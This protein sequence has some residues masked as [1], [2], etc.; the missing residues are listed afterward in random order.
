MYILLVFFSEF[1]FIQES[2]SIYV[3]P[4]FANVYGSYINC[5]HRSMSQTNP[6]LF[7]RF[8][9]T[10]C[11]YCTLAI[12]FCY[13]RFLHSQKHSPRDIFLL[14]CYKELHLHSDRTNS[15]SYFHNLSHRILAKKNPLLKV[16]NKWRC[17]WYL[18]TA[19]EY[20][21]RNIK[22]YVEYK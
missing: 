18:F 4:V 20:I 13:N 2:S 14:S 19:N 15:C 8:T 11:F 21:V 5:V 7:E 6:C 1:C 22:I 10:L 17:I 3:H 9:C 16:Q 12:Y